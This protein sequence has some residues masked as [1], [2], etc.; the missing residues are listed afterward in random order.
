MM[1]RLRNILK[2]IISRI[3]YPNS[4][5]SDVFVRYLKQKGC[6]V[7]ERV[8]FFDP[9]TVF[10]D[11]GRPALLEIKDGAKITRNVI[12][13]THDF[14]FSVFRPVYHQVMN[15]CAGTTIVGN[16][17]FLGMGCIIM[18]GVKLGENVIV[19]SGSVVTKSFPDNVVIAG[20]PAKV[21]CP[22]DDFYKKRKDRQ[23]QDAVNYVKIVNE[24]YNMD[25][26]IKEMGGFASL[27]LPRK[28]K[29]IV[30]SGIKWSWSGDEEASVLK[31]IYD[32]EPLFTSYEEFLNYAHT[33]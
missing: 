24:K 9:T 30:M 15:E 25:P 4:Y 17:N 31:D 20:N 8:F 23:L 3:L 26:S 16:N 5:R 27:F 13:L 21:I 1:R 6:S 10:V 32:S 18:P 33:H 2:S 28:E 22:L 19:G 12:I 14:S 29:D 11:T 7:G